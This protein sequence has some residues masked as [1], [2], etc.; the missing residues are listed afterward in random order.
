MRGVWIENDVWILHVAGSGLL[1]RAELSAPWH[2]VLQ[3]PDEQQR[4]SQVGRLW[5]GQVVKNK[6]SR[7]ECWC[8]AHVATSFRLYNAEDKERPYTNKVITL[9]YRWVNIYVETKFWCWCCPIKKS[10]SENESDQYVWRPPELLLGEERYGPAIDVWS[11]GCILGE[12]FEKK[13]LFQVHLLS[14]DF[15]PA[16]N[17]KHQQWKV[18]VMFFSSGKWGVCSA[19][20]NQQ[21]VWHTLPLRLAWG[22]NM[23]KTVLRTPQF[24][25]TYRKRW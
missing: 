5:V 14:P 22:D 2:Q 23:I 19:Y 3:H 13:P 4:P 25:S 18:C 8:V 12:L 9:W 16:F 6:Y 15:V 24:D 1:P 21:D 17:S 10:L 11:C 20:G 7:L